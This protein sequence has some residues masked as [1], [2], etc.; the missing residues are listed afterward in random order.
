MAGSLNKAQIIGHLG[1]DPE[2]RHGHTGNAVTRLSVATNERW[3]DKQGERQERTEWHRVVMF[4]R[5]AEIAAE[6][7]HKGDLVYL[8]G[9]L[10]TQKWQDK[11]G[12]DRWTTEIVATEMTMLGSR[13]GRH[14][15]NAGGQAYDVGAMQGELIEGAP[16]PAGGGRDGLVGMRDEV[17]Q[18]RAAAA[19]KPSADFDE[20]IPF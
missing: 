8:E 5:L 1:A 13:D 19:G 12:L 14:G 3:K 6:Y 20:D 17:A 16:P 11:Q 4:G 2:T 7:L 15:G 9:R 18:R 10:Q